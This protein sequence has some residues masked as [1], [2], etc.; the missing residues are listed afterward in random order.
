MATHGNAM[1][2]IIVTMGVLLTTWAEASPTREWP[3]YRFR[4]VDEDGKPVIAD[5]IQMLYVYYPPRAG[6]APYER[7]CLWWLPD[8]DKVTENSVAD[9]NSHSDGTG[10]IQMHD[11]TCSPP[12]S[13]VRLLRAYSGGRKSIKILARDLRDEKR[14]IVFLFP[15]EQGRAPVLKRPPSYRS[16]HRMFDPVRWRRAAIA[17][18]VRFEDADGDPLRVWWGNG[19][20]V[21]E[22]MDSIIGVGYPPCREFVTACDPKGNC[23]PGYLDMHLSPDDVPPGTA[24]SNYSC[25]GDGVPYPPARP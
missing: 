20:N 17:V 15:K 7:I 8:Q 16:L 22:G 11:G 3:V 10:L 2:R 12:G 9:M 1:R 23:T 21:T 6:L 13:G 24:P 19:G 5:K 4:C 25:D 14:E 18:S